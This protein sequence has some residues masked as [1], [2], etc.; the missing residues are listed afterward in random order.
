MVLVIEIKKKFNPKLIK[1]LLS[2]KFTYFTEGFNDL[3]RPL[4]KI[5][6]ETNSTTIGDALMAI[7]R[8]RRLPW[9]T[10]V[11][12]NMIINAIKLPVGLIKLFSADIW[13]AYATVPISIKIKRK[14]KKVNTY[15]NNKPSSL[16]LAIDVFKIDAQ[17]RKGFMIKK[18]IKIGINI[19][20][21]KAYVVLTYCLDNVLSP[22]AIDSVNLFR[23]PLLNPISKKV[24]H[25]TSELTVS[26]I[27]YLSL[28]RYP[29]QRGTK[30][31]WIIMLNPFS[32]N[33]K[34]IFF[35]TLILRSCPFE[36]YALII[37]ILSFNIILF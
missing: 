7:P 5:I 16:L 36:K 35:L 31:N 28:S 9:E 34:I 15:A 1:F 18:I 13:L 3:N 12:M 25:V 26:H 4:Y 33:D 22:F 27:P 29:R 21:I 32:V 10:L 17:F 19:N 8:Y 2:E 23:I 20:N 37:L 14:I 11:R 30:N 24:N 6:E